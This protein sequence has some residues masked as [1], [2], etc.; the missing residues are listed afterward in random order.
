MADK[1]RYLGLYGTQNSQMLGVRLMKLTYFG[2]VIGII[3]RKFPDGNDGLKHRDEGARGL[4]EMIA[5]E[6]DAHT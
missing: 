4:L 6:L 3:S 2:L 5:R 1:I